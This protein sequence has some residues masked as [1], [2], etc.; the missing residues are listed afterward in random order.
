VIDCA[1]EVH[2][3]LGAGLLESTYEKCLVI[4][5]SQTGIELTVQTPL[6]LEYKEVKL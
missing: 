4:E 5:L 1:I 2:R 3:L 6:P